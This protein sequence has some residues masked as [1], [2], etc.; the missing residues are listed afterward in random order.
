LQI[1]GIPGVGGL[2]HSPLQNA[3]LAVALWEPGP[4]RS[5]AEGPGL[6]REVTGGL[7]VP[8]GILASGPV[9]ACGARARAVDLR[10]S[11]PRVQGCPRATTNARSPDMI[12]NARRYLSV[13]RTNPNAGSVVAQYA[14]RP[15]P[16]RRHVRLGER[17][18]HVAQ[19]EGPE[20]E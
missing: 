18:E 4:A 20:A 9:S 6:G 3:T 1:R 7:P 11:G 17:C 12:E 14:V 8:P 10:P 2:R 13:S 16:S 5:G 19:G 15:L